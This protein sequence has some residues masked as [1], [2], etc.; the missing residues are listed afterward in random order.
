MIPF[1]ETA[2]EIAKKQREEKHDFLL[3]TPLTRL[4]MNLPV[5]EMTADDHV[6]VCGGSSWNAGRQ[7]WW[8]TSA[9]A[10]ISQLDSCN[11]LKGRAKN[12]VRMIKNVMLGFGETLHQRDPERIK[13]FLRSCDVRI[14]G[15]GIYAED[16]TVNLVY[17]LGN[18]LDQSPD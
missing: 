9:P 18:R 5:K 7:A 16:N 15:A 13:S 12:P 2:G 6:S 14:R 4:V 17:L 1:L 8:L 3:E 10:I 11:N